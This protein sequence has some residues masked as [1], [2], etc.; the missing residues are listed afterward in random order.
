MSDCS[1]KCVYR[2][3]GQSPS[4]APLWQRGSSC[5]EIDCHCDETQLPQSADINELA[6]V[7]CVPNEALSRAVNTSD[8]DR[9]DVQPN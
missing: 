8:V 5:T 3:V 2:C 1:G 7:S 9:I 6:Y 4:G